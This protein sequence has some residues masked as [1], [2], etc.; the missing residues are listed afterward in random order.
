MNAL[1]AV[2]AILGVSASGPLMAATTAP[3][4]AIAFWRNAAAS[5]VTAEAA[6][7][8]SLEVTG[9]VVE[10]GSSHSLTVGEKTFATARKSDIARG[11]VDWIADWLGR[12]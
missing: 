11:L 2:V 4:L 10:S 5:A 1:L 6:S 3:A 9:R 7:A 12:A 8:A